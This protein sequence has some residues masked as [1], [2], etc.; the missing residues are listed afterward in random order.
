MNL[1]QMITADE[2]AKWLGVTRRVLLSKCRGRRP[3]I[4]GFWINRRVVRFHPRTVLAALSRRAGLKEDLIDAVARNSFV[5]NTV[6]TRACFTPRAANG[7]AALLL[8]RKEAA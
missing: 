7:K 5:L 8:S 6:E 4:P 2:C 3:V 1:D